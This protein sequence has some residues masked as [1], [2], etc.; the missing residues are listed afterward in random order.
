VDI[1]ISFMNSDQQRALFAIYTNAKVVSS[2]RTQ[3]PGPVLA[4]PGSLIGGSAQGARGGIEIIGTETETR[5]GRTEETG[6]E[7]IGGTGGIATE[8]I[9]IDA[10]IGT[11]GLVTLIDHPVTL[12]DRPATLIG[13][14]A[15]LIDHVNQTDLT[16]K[17]RDT[18][19]NEGIDPTEMAA[20]V[21]MKIKKGIHKE[22][23]LTNPIINTELYPQQRK[24]AQFQIIM[25][26]K[27]E[28]CGVG[29][30]ECVFVQK[31][32]ILQMCMYAV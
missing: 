22:N 24:T 19:K 29:K 13:H 1:V 5:V 3:D 28:P 25:T 15:I 7:I 20:G 31:K 4:A 26:T 16:E 30:N 2:T 9:E 32:I 27:F 21:E 18:I 17:D 12:I 6:T 23:P 14:P 8:V 11:T 10:E